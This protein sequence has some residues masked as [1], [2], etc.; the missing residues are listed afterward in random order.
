MS[1]SE[2]G[3]NQAFPL[4]DERQ[5]YIVESGYV[6]IFAVMVSN[7]TR[8][9]Q[10]TTKP[11]VTRVMPEN[12]FFGAPDVTVDGGG[13]PVR[14]VL[15][16]VPS[17][18]T[19][20]LTGERAN[21][22]SKD[23]FDLDTVVLIDNWVKMAGEFVHGHELPPPAHASSL[24]EADADM[25]Y[26]AGA[27]L[28]AHHLE[29]LWVTLDRPARFV[30]RAEFP[31]AAG[32]TLP[33]SEHTWLTLP[34]DARASAVH[35]PGAI[36][37]GRIWEAVDR[38]NSQ[39]VRCGKLY[40]D[41][42]VE[43]AELKRAENQRSVAWAR[44]SLAGGFAGLLDKTPDMGGGELSAAGDNPLFEA[45]RIVA[46]TLGVALN[47]PVG[48]IEFDDLAE[49]VENLVVASGIRTRQVNL[50]GGW[51]RRSG[52]SFLGWLREG[53]DARPVAVVNRGS[54]VYEIADP[55]AGD[56]VPV[57]RELAKKL[58]TEGLLFYAPLPANVDNGLAALRH[59]MRGR[60]RDIMGVVLMG[61]LGALTALLTPVLT[62]K[63]LA[64]I[65][66][67]VDIPMWS[68]ALAALALGALASAAFAIVGAL[69]MLRLEAQVDESLQSA[70]WNRLLSL[71]LPFFGQY[72]A[73]DLADRANG[74]S[75]VRQ[76]LTGAVGSSILSG[77]F[78]IFSYALLFYYSW[79]LALWS[80]LAVAVMAVATW[81]FAK[82]QIRHARASLMIQGMIDAF[83]FQV[84]KGLGKIRQA[85]AEAFVLERWSGEYLKQKRAQLSMRNWEA[86]QLTFNAL[87]MPAVQIVLLGLIWYS[88]LRGETQT[89]F[90]LGDFLSFYAAFGQFIGGVTGLTAALAAAAAVLPLFERIQPIL[91]A[92]PES[93][94][95]RVVLPRP[96]GQIEFKNVNF[97]YPSADADVLRNV[98]L[99]IGHGEYVAF[100]GSSGAGKSTLYRLIL[101]FERPTTGTVLIDGHDMETLNLSALRK[102]MGVVLQ[103]G[104]LLPDSIRNNIAGHSHLT[105]AQVQEAVRAAGLEEDIDALPMRLSTVLPESG[106]GLSGGQKQRLLVARALAH[107]PSMLLFDEATSMLDNRAQDAIRAT[108]RSLNSTRILIAHRLST[109]VDADRIYVMQDGQIVEHGKYRELME[110]NGALAEMARRQVI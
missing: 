77:M 26:Q 11:F 8:N 65:I 45:S 19:A 71:P 21:L 109:V 108:L 93:V 51:E 78:S 70:V 100:I 20:L 101:G 39:I 29:I 84:I 42:S 50:A 44:K 15:L 35:T 22:L 54:G 40:W 24:L 37:T 90:S 76:M 17:R 57:T 28:S 98:S 67:R 110:R 38:F 74:V 58:G 27:A 97:R 4:T 9:L 36:V 48:R 47:P 30:G 33:I 86:G 56:R 104:Q 92:R 107:K 62:G 103:D 99:K 10:L 52:P 82:N 31:V 7:D 6:D 34:E 23:D 25:P 41:E 75:L 89:P 14:H 63:L 66:P 102:H 32:A 72:L 87:F 60:G 1:R 16:A 81:I 79:E 55:A 106:A 61:C 12:A 43:K 49:A 73:G 88:L 5:F 83:V 80:G 46:E 94:E 91:E 105:D 53:A 96:A 59:V 13:E 64:E 18:D 68:A 95:G 2:M 69:C 3:A 85:H